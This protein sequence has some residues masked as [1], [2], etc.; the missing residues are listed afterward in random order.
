MLKKLHYVMQVLHLIVVKQPTYLLQ[1]YIV[2]VKLISNS[3][4][5]KASLKLESM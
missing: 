5:I 1:N 3:L 2:S 4:Q